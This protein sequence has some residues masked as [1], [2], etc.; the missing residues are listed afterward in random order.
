MIYY[1]I[2]QLS[3][4]IFLKVKLVIVGLWILGFLCAIPQA[5]TFELVYETLPDGTRIENL[6]ACNIAERYR[7]FSRF[8][9]VFSAFFMFVLPM[10]LI[11][12][13]YIHIAITLRKSEIKVNGRESSVS[14]GGRSSRKQQLR[15]ADGRHS[16]HKNVLAVLGN[17]LISIFFSFR[18]TF[19]IFVTLL[20]RHDK[21]WYTKSCFS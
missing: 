14:V 4:L 11:T 2:D 10:V 1:L 6:S 5:I 20:V 3:I 12:V 13:L 8:S 18:V 19:Q 16:Q 7:A 15:Q 17:D 9:F 21:H